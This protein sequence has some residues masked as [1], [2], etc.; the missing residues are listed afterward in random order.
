MINGCEMSAKWLR[1]ECEIMDVKWVR[2]D[3]E[4]VAKWVRNGCKI[5]YEMDAKLSSKWLR[6][7]C[8]MTAIIHNWPIIVNYDQFMPNYIIAKKQYLFA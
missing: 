7:G 6:N 5:E 2:N 4:M 3:C 8:E 1:N